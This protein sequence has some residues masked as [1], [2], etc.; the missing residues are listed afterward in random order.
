MS[1]CQGAGGGGNAQ[2]ADMG[3]PP[4][5]SSLANKPDRCSVTSAGD[6]LPGE[7]VGGQSQ[8]HHCFQPS[9]GSLCA[10]PSRRKRKKR[11]TGGGEGT[12]DA[13]DGA[14]L[15]P[16]PVHRPVAPLTQWPSPLKKQ[17]V[18][19]EVPSAATAGTI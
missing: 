17:Y 9:F 7:T 1:V 3:E 14:Q 2:V 11:K 10:S 5:A 13:V 19:V 4:A 8:T 16:A 15:R 6:I 12:V 18:E